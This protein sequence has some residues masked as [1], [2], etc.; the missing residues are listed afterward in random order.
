[1]PDTYPIDGGRMTL[2]LS[3]TR[4]PETRNATTIAVKMFRIQSSNN[5]LRLKN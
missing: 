3:P 1:M 2:L 4:I 5:I